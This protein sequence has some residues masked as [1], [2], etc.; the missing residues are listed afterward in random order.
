MDGR[1]ASWLDYEPGADAAGPIWTVTHTVTLPELRGRGLADRLVAH[2]VSVAAA[3][4]VRI[5]PLCP[6]VRSWLLGHPEHAD[7]VV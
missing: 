2:A 1:L 6:Y 3:D 7:I 5:R 4:G